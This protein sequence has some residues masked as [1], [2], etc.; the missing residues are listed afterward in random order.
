MNTPVNQ[1]YMRETLERLRQLLG[2]ELPEPNTPAFEQALRRVQRDQPDLLDALKSLHDPDAL[3]IPNEVHR[4]NLKEFAGAAR[5]AKSVESTQNLLN[6]WFGIKDPRRNKTHFNYRLMSLVLGGL[7]LV[8]GAVW[9]FW[10]DLSRAFAGREPQ[11]A[12]TAITAPIVTPT[13]PNSVVAATPSPQGPQGATPPVP[14]PEAALPGAAGPGFDPGTFPPAPVPPGVQTAAGG[15]ANN[16]GAVPPPPLPTYSATPVPPPMPLDGSH[17]QVAGGPPP[18]PAFNPVAVKRAEHPTTEASM[19]AIRREAG[20]VTTR[21]YMVLGRQDAAQGPSHV[22]GLTPGSNEHKVLEGRPREGR[23]P[24]A[25]QRQ[26]T[27]QL[28]YTAVRQPGPQGQYVALAPVERRASPGQD[29]ASVAPSA[30]P[31]SLPTPTPVPAPAPV[32]APDPSP[33]QAAPAPPARDLLAPSFG[34]GPLSSPALPTVTP[35]VALT[36]Y[37]FEI[38]DRQDAELISGVVIP[39]GSSQAALMVRTRDG[40]VFFGAATLDRAGRLQVQFDRAYKGRRAYVVR[41]IGLDERGVAGIPAVVSEQAP[42]LLNNLLRGAASGL[43][44]FVDFYA[45]S[46]ATTILPGGGIATATV[47][48]PLGLTIL[49]GSARQIAAPPDS[50]SVVRVWSLDPGTRMQVLIVPGE[51]GGSGR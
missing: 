51:V 6:H 50:T 12:E 7:V 38:G 15:G 45:R 21:S 46:S 41:A 22:A 8:G 26:A 10:P 39:E 13:D 17:G 3:P 25:L 44:A 33:A 1:E 34:N 2:G 27:E 43:V 16:A 18:P 4:N 14:V 47:P 42:N 31:P 23:S 49:S 35:N 9:A 40:F 19:V 48:P 20:A 11:L 32:P 29:N 28:E 30:P 37:P 5:R 24:V 36:E